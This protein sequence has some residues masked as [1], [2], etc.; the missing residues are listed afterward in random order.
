MEYTVNW[1][2]ELD[3]ESF[4][5]AAKKALEIQRDPDST[6]THF[7]VCDEHGRQQEV[8][9]EGTPGTAATVH[10]L[11]PMEEGLVRGVRVFMT[12]R[13]AQRAEAEWLAAHELTDEKLR[14]EASDWGTGIAIWQCD[15]KLT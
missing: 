1:K 15:L 2:I 5:D 9:L 3:A 13:S 11:I 12:E 4:E 7:E 6:A 10:V 8:D 14:E